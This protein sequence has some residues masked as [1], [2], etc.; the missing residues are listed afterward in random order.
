MNHVEQMRSS[1]GKDRFAYQNGSSEFGKIVAKLSEQFGQADVG[2]W[3]SV[4][5]PQ[6][7]SIY[8]DDIVS[9]I[10]QIR[11]TYLDA[12]D[13]V[14]MGRKFFLRRR[15]VYDKVYLFTSEKDCN[16]PR[17]IDSQPIGVGKLVSV[18]GQ[19][20][21]VNLS[22]YQCLYFMHKDHAQVE[23]WAKRSLPQGRYSTFY[24]ATFDTADNNKLLRMKS[25]LY[26]EQSALSDWDVVWSMEAKK[27]GVL[28]SATE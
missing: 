21:D 20:G 24:A 1:D 26:D 8:D 12:L 19:P 16:L 18:Y 22:R 27:R 13:P 14:V 9:V 4:S 17:P 25:Y 2:G 15:W 23:Q 5:T 7:N 28:D 6:Y 10:F 3:F 11:P